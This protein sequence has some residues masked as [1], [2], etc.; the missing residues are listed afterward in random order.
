M[1][2]KCFSLA[3]NLMMLLPPQVSI[4]ALCS[5]IHKC[6]IEQGKMKES[7]SVI[8]EKIYFEEELKYLLVALGPAIKKDIK[9]S[10]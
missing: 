8:I 5:C 2:K 1:I 6:A 7:C 9:L 4:D 3:P 10:D